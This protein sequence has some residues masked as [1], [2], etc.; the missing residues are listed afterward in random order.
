[1]LNKKTAPHN[2]YYVVERGYTHNFRKDIFEKYI[3]CRNNTAAGKD[4]QKIVFLS[5]AL[6]RYRQVEKWAL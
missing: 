3:K 2:R 4:R 5:V 1:M 6:C